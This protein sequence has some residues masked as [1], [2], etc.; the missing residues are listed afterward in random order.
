LQSQYR[1]KSTIATN[2]ESWL[3]NFIREGGFQSHSIMQGFTSDPCWSNPCL[4]SQFEGPSLRFASPPGKAGTPRPRQ[5]LQPDESHNKCYKQLSLI[6]IA[7]VWTIS[8]ESFC[9]LRKVFCLLGV[10]ATS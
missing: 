7:T 8:F 1:N 4:S 9:N 6:I 10:T 3:M 5:R 2:N